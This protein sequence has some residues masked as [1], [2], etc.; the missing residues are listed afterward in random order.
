MNRFFNWLKAVFNRMM[1][2]LED[3]DMMLDQAKRDMQESLIQNRE[4]AVQAIT[5]K[6]RLQQMLNEAEKKSAQLESQAAMALKQGNRD[7]ARQFMREKTN[8]DA[9]LETLRASLTQALQT[10][11]AVKI[12]IKRQEEE[13]RK[14]TAEALAMKAQWK[15]AQIQNSIAKALEGLTF[16]NQLDS[17]NAAAERIKDA[18][19]EALARQEMQADS[20][21]GKIM[22]MQDQA[23]DYQAE[24]EL[25]KLEEKLGMRPKTA[26]VEP[27]AVQTVSVGEGVAANQ[28]AIEAS[29]SDIDRQLAELEKRMQSHEKEL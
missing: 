29:V 6:N 18:Q 20:I 2:R 17:F 10:V 5:Q 19:S 15:Q 23:M 13:V 21:Q 9:V 22:Q 4:R 3:P 11:E 12:A 7:L 16:E 26:E 27:V 28:P 14:K 24:E 1:N 25:Q 8:N